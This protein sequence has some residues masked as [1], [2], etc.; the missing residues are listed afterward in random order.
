[1]P[2]Q[3]GADGPRVMVADGEAARATPVNLGADQGPLV[4]VTGGLTEADRLVV[5]GQR[6]L[7]D[8]ARLFVQE[9]TTER[10]GS[11]PADPDAVRLEAEGGSR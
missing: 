1:M 10:D 8:G 9:E 6:D 2:W 11:L 4:M 7:T 3:T 5:R